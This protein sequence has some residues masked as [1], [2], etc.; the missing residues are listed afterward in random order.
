MAMLWLCV[1]VHVVLQLQLAQATSPPAAA[2]TGVCPPAVLKL[3][4]RPHSF[5]GRSGHC[6]LDVGWVIALPQDAAAAE[7]LRRPAEMLAAGI[8]NRT[9]LRI[10]ISSTAAAHVIALQLS[11]SGP[12][13]SGPQAFGTVDEGYRLAI[14]TT[15]VSMAASTA[16][17]VHYSTRTFL[18]LLSLSGQAPACVIDDKPDLPVR[19]FYLDSKPSTGLNETFF[20]ELAAKMGDLKMNSLI[21]HNEAFIAL[22]G[23]SGRA[24]KSSTLARLKNVSAVLAANQIDM[25]AEIGP[26]YSFGSFEGAF[27]CLPPC[28]TNWL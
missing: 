21:L 4:P 22:S 28:A 26:Y 8:E 25:I 12:L 14:N 7:A 18:Q 11:S 17:G 24:I 19:G 3:S 20:A 1:Q 10:K 23:A 2:R 27:N 6:A 9:G 5:V 16:R 15:S 13:A